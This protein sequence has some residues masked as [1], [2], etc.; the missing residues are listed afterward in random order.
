[1][2]GISARVKNSLLVNP[3]K[4]AAIIITSGNYEP[5]VPQSSGDAEAAE[6]RDGNDGDS[7]GFHHYSFPSLGSY[8]STNSS[9]HSSENSSFSTGSMPDFYNS[10]STSDIA[11]Y[12]VFGC[13]LREARQLDGPY[14]NTDVLAPMDPTDKLYC[15]ITFSK[16]IPLFVLKCLRFITIHGLE[17]EGLYRISGSTNDI[18]ALKERFCRGKLLKKKEI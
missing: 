17:E 6:S 15:D 5:E 3:K 8:S 1:M 12:N 18:R 7:S 2:I 16:Y 4:Q 14:E 11:H 9:S 13:S 10:F